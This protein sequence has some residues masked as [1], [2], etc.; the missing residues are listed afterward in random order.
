MFCP[1]ALALLVDVSGSVSLENLRLQQQAYVQSFREPRIRNIILSQ[2][3]IAL[4][5]VEWDSEPS[6]V[7]EWT[8]VETAQDLEAFVIQLESNV[9]MGS[10]GMTGMARAIKETIASAPS[11]PCEVGRFVID[12]SGDG[13][14]NVTGKVDEVRDIAQEAG[15]TINGLPIVTPTPEGRTVVQFYR[16]N[17]I[18]HDGFN[19]VVEG[20]E[21]ILGGLNRKLNREIAG[22]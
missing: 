17:V 2:A 16:E 6:P 1:V 8:L 10:R 21:S 18:T 19:I 11:I 5:Y 9:I 12:I 20:Y 14:D 4:R 22:N 15:I 7:V 3:P 13:D